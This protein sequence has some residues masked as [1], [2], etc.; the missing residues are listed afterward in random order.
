MKTILIIT[1]MLMGQE[2]PTQQALDMKDLKQCESEAHSFMTHKFPA[3]V[4][5][6]ITFRSAACALTLPGKDT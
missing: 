6:R 5:S 3:E 2:K 4:Q 1:L